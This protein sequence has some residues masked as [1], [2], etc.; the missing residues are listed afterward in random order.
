MNAKV[1]L[2]N[3]YE[4]SAFKRNQNDVIVNILLLFEICF[5]FVLISSI[6]A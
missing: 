4:K 6:L 5:S 3:K 1:C 2:Q